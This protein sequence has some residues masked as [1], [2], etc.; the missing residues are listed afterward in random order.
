MIMDVEAQLLN[1]LYQSMEETVHA[2]PNL[3][4]VEHHNVLVRKLCMENGNIWTDD[5]TKY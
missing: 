1:L 4:K 2:V 3:L 5:L